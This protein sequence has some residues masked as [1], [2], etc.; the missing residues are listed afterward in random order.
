VYHFCPYEDLAMRGSKMHSKL[1]ICEFSFDKKIKEMAFHQAKQK[2]F[3]KNIFDEE[4]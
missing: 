1:K 2:K 4:V 3:E